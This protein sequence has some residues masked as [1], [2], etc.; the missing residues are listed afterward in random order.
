MKTK[1]REINSYRDL[2]KKVNLEKLQAMRDETKKEGWDDPLSPNYRPFR[3]YYQDYECKL[4]KK[5]IP[6]PTEDSV[7][8]CGISETIEDSNN[9]ENSKTKRLKEHIELHRLIKDLKL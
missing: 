3:V 8:Q 7:W 2:F 9:I 6:I 5:I 1:I 4:C